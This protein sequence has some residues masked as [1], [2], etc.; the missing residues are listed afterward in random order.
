MNP[1][2]GMILGREPRQL[3]EALTESGNVLASTQRVD[4]K[5]RQEGDEADRQKQAIK[6]IHR[7][8]FKL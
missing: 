8:E 3:A 4:G 5:L 6:E 1:N 7:L 2:D